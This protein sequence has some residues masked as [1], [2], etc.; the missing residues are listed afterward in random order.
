MLALITYKNLFPKDFAELQ[1]NRGFVY[2]LFE[3]KP[4]FIKVKREHVEKEIVRLQAQ[5]ELAAKAFITSDEIDSIIN[6][7][8]PYYRSNP[9]V[10]LKQ[11][12]NQA[13]EFYAAKTISEQESTADALN[14]LKEELARLEHA[15]LCK[16]LSRDNIDKVFCENKHVD[17][18]GTVTKFEE[19]KQSDY[20]ALLKY[21]V[22]E[23]HIEE[24]YPDYMTYFYPESISKNDKTFLRSVADKKELGCRYPLD[25][26]EKVISRL[27]SVDFDQ[28]ETLNFALLNYV[29]N[30]GNET[31]VQKLL[32]QLK[33][34]NNIAFI[35][36]YLQSAED[37]LVI[38]ISKLNVT[39]SSFFKSALTCAAFQ[40]DNRV[41]WAK[42]TLCVTQVE[43]IK[44]VNEDNCL[45]DF[46]SETPEFL[47]GEP[48][49]QSKLIHGMQL[50]GVEMKTIC[51]EK[52]NADLLK[53]VYEKNLY[54]LNAS[55]ILLMLNL[56]YKD[57]S[58]AKLGSRSYSEIMKPPMSPLAKRVQAFINNYLD[59][60]FQTCN[61]K[62]EDDPNDA[63]NILNNKS[64]SSERKAKY[65]TL[66]KTII[67]SLDDIEDLSLWGDLLRHRRVVCSPNNIV[68]YF[69]GRENTIDDVLVAFINN[70][71]QDELCFSDDD[72][73]EDDEQ[74]AAFFE[75]VVV[76]SGIE[77]SRYELILGSLNQ[78][79]VEFDVEEMPIEK[80][81]ILIKL[82]KIG[83]TNVSLDNI[84][85]NYS[86]CL[87][88]FIK[89]QFDDY[90]KLVP[91][92]CEKNELRMIL[93]SSDFTEE[94]KNNLLQITTAPISVQGLKCS[95]TLK[96]R[97]LC[98]NW[99][100]NDTAYLVQHYAEFTPDT[101]TQ[102]VSCLVGNP[103]HLMAERI[104]L[105]IPLLDR[106]IE[107]KTML[108]GDQKV[109][110]FANSLDKISDSATCQAYLSRLHLDEFGKVFTSGRPKILT[111]ITA[112]AH[113]LEHFK[114]N[115][116]ISDYVKDAS[117]PDYFK[118]KKNK[119]QD[120]ADDNEWHH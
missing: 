97:I 86:E 26:P 51:R 106:L 96:A 109:D 75:N 34:S 116:W 99:D 23:G 13:K 8:D 81:S 58:M 43:T 56:F 63:C 72:L 1:L 46:I 59:I 49:D 19:I 70:G 117:R 104:S 14:K 94:Q 66:L 6:Y 91:N 53:A 64:V 77:N 41:L 3:N 67:K 28:P 119:N 100:S 25:S 84:R 21:L 83:M 2:A 60:V 98:S 61:G 22:R 113:I 65:I 11:K 29:L 103:S 36:D 92:L 30:Y 108:V 101:Q 17:G 79:Y 88:V 18:N 35:N 9:F 37:S 31:Y 82:G 115:N 47:D 102:I 74:Q 71:K 80:V 112:H 45:R 95:E 39:W 62:I 85:G 40:S 24:G 69:T 107:D 27:S 5:L 38:I 48:L 87:P 44:T 110:L 89:M 16:L 120:E 118:I 52:A 15:K 20:F 76:C 73:F 33:A 111:D 78:S 93:S 10:A 50:I 4:N 12:L 42:T 7:Q 90:L 54:A 114:K 32:D 55:N 68:C 105:P 57:N